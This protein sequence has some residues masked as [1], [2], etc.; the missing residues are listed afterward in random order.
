MCVETVNPAG[1]NKPKAPGK[2]GQGQ[3]QDGYYEL[4]ADDALDPNPKIFVV[5]KGID[6]I[7]DTPDDAAFPNPAPGF[8]SGTKI[9]YTEAKGAPPS[10]RP[11]T[12]VIDWK[13]SG[14][15]D[16]AVFA[17]DAAGNP[18]PPVDCLVPPPPK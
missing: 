8:P 4:L 18:S 10:I 9:K 11:G 16:A 17:L 2:G 5:D 14:Q 7:F 13:I 15:G 6:N 3:N 12:G 1:K